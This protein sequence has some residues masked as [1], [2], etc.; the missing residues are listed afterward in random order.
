MILL[1]TN[2]ARKGANRPSM[3]SLKIVHNLYINKNGITIKDLSK[4]IQTDYKNVYDS[5]SI[6]FNDGVIKKEK[7]G[8]YN[9][10]KLNYSNE[11]IAEYLK[12]YD[13]Y[14][15]SRGFRKKHPIEYRIIIETCEQL[16]KEM[17]PFFICLVFGSYAKN[18]EQKG[19]D[20]DVLFLTFFSKA[21]GMIKKILNKI[22]APYQ[23]KFHIIEQSIEN[24]IKDLKNKDKLSIAT[25]IY[26]EPPI[27]FYGDDIFFKIMVD[28]NK[29]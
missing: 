22:N 9:I 5:V 13:F 12:E 10:C 23:K 21:E 15:K 24:F 18:E 14:V 29:P 19:S 2:M 26:K 17:S 8:N 28:A 11:D 16:K 6:L 4:N 3:L 7:I 25:E 1:H 20:I 27:V